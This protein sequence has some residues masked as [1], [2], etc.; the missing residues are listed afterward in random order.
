MRG[1]F[2]DYSAGADSVDWGCHVEF[3][4]AKYPAA[5]SKPG[6]FGITDSFSGTEWCGG[7]GTELF[8]KVYATTIA[9]KSSSTK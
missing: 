4:S 7:S 8:A 1:F 3:F 5:F 9:G 6:F 2:D